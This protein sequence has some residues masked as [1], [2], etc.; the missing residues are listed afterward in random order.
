[1]ILKWRAED[2]VRVDNYRRI[3]SRRYHAFLLTHF[4]FVFFKQ[5]L[6]E[7]LAQGR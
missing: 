5:P 1:M 4:I 6:F 7:M 2:R 3:E